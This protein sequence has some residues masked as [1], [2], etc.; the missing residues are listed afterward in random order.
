M[1]RHDVFFGRKGTGTFFGLGAGG[2]ARK[3]K[4]PKNEP[5]PGL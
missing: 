1:I 4:R 5:V 3:S 2:A